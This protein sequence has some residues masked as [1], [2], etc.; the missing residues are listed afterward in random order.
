MLILRFKGS[1]KVLNHIGKSPN[2]DGAAD[3][4]YLHRLSEIVP[5]PKRWCDFFSNNGTTMI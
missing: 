1:H 2:G 4:S 5:E 3:G